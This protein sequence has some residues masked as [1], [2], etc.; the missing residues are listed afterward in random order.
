MS[1]AFWY[2]K[3]IKQV[4]MNP[5]TLDL[6]FTL[7][8]QNWPHQMKFIQSDLK[9]NASGETCKKYGRNDLSLSPSP[10]CLLN[11]THATHW[12]STPPRCVRPTPTPWSLQPH[13]YYVPKQILVA[14]QEHSV[15]SMMVSPPKDP[16]ETAEKESATLQLNHQI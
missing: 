12:V 13:M 9:H 4:M 6:C 1:W 10:A 11:T 15:S 2:V 7:Y 8:N 14:G 16:G 3:H 5:S